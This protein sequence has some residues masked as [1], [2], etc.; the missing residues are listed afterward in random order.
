MRGFRVQGSGFRRRQ[1]S[2]VRRQATDRRGGFLS[3]CNLQFAIRNLQFLRLATFS[4]VVLLFN[5]PVRADGG[6]SVAALRV[7]FK[8]NYRVGFWTP[9]EVT[10]R[11]GPRTVT[12]RLSLSLPDGDAVRTELVTE[13]VE[14]PAGSETRVTS[15]LKFGALQSSLTLRFGDG[16]H[17]WAT[18]TFQAGSGITDVE[19]HKAFPSTQS[20][21][22]TLGTAI[23]VEE[24]IGRVRG[25]LDRTNVINLSDAAQLPD[26]WLGY[27]G[28][29]K[30]VLG[31]APPGLDAAFTDGSKRLAALERWLTEGGRLLLALGTDSPHHLSSDRPLARFLPGRL[32]EVAMLNRTT[33][34]EML[35]GVPLRWPRGQRRSVEAVRLVDVRGH[36]DLAEGDFPLFVR[37]SYVF[38]EVTFSAVDFSRPPLADWAGRNLS[39]KRL[40]GQRGKVAAGNDSSDVPPPA[41]QLGLVDLSAQLRSALDQFRGV[42]LAPFWAVAALAAVYIA[43][44]GP[45]DFLL[46]KTVVRKMELTWITFPLVVVALCGG[47]FWAASRMK[48]QRLLVNQIDLVDVD[49]ASGRV[50]GS[51]WFNLFSPATTTYNLSL[52]PQIGDS[53]TDE[54][55]EVLLSWQGLPGNVLGG[56]EHTVA[57]PSGVARPYRFV[58][59]RS[60]LEDVPVPIWSSKSFVGRWQTEAT[61]TLDADLTSGR[62]DVVEGTL[63]NRLGLPLRRCLLVAGRWAWEF[64]ELPPGSPVRVR[65]GEQRDLVALLKDFKLVRERDRDDLI[66]MAT[67]YDPASFNPRS[68][69]QQM[70]FY[71]AANGRTYTGLL[72]R[73]QQCIDLSDHLQLGQAILWGQADR[74]AADIL[75]DG[76]PLEDA[77]NEHATFYRFLVPLDQGRRMKDEAVRR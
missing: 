13:P 15:Y 62:D 63:I 35:G 21:V 70:M 74:P 1:A 77:Q 58:A 6:V 11:G 14:V 76:E 72:N 8:G 65:P 10:L 31:P 18:E 30:L 47:V 19:F 69:L 56:M 68:I 40:L 16:E 59:D 23:G 55:H 4:I 39:L 53:R 54:P 27:E 75:R 24:A 12:G 71:E 73:Y 45:L 42:S 49:L 17:V 60:Q 22:L 26:D 28:V 3:I 20:L 29:E 67:P 33:A 9:V 50:R 66:Q 46:L 57:A 7:G 36:I 5:A 52:K 61:A 32:E 41:A 44:V 34:L 48:S 37:R 38:G 64:D 51:T 2:G 43:L 25:P